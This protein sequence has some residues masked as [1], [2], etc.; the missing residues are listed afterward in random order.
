MW[1]AIAQGRRFPAP[2]SA[3]NVVLSIVG[4]AVRRWFEGANR[5]DCDLDPGTGAT[6][7]GGSVIVPKFSR[8]P[9]ATLALI[10]DPE[11]HVPG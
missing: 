2:S 3:L 5:G 9:N 11:G 10:A 7:L 8:G 1:V 4:P 6:E